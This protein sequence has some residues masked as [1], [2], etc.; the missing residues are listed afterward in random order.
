MD[1]R[2]FPILV[3]SVPDVAFWDMMLQG[4]SQ[5]VQSVVEIDIIIPYMGDLDQIDAQLS[6]KSPRLAL[7]Q[8]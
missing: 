2:R 7:E 1:R 5:F 3:W 8:P 6:D 4:R